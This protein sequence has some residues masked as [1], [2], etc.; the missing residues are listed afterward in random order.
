MIFNISG[1]A[2]ISISS[3]G[4]AWIISKKV[5][6]GIV[7]SP[8]SK[9][10]QFT[11]STTPISKFVAESFSLPD[12]VWIKILANT[13]RVDLTPTDRETDCKTGSRSDC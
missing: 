11:L 9:I 4:S 2:S 3:D 7:I 13:G 10:S 1:V 8:S 5:L 6:A 12:W